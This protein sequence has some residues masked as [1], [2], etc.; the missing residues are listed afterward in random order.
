MSALSVKCMCILGT[1]IQTSHNQEIKKSGNDN[2]K[3]KHTDL[4]SLITLLRVIN[5]NE[6]KGVPRTGSIWLPCPSSQK[7]TL[8]LVRLGCALRWIMVTRPFMF[9]YYFSYF[10]LFLKGVKLFMLQF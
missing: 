6:E 9:H 8:S 7:V 1:E 10:L 4:E 3:E 5:R 2:N